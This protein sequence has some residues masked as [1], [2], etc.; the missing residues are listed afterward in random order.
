[1]AVAV[2]DST[3]VTILSDNPIP[4]IGDDNAIVDRTQQ[5]TSTFLFAQ[6]QS[7]QNDATCFRRIVVIVVVLP[8]RINV[9][10]RVMEK[11][12]AVGRWLSCWAALIV[13][14]SREAELNLLQLLQLP[15]Q[16]L[17]D[18]F[19]LPSPHIVL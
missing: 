9:L 17:D 1:M 4:R 2:A 11:R 10:F 15:R 13:T 14:L 19:S 6:A 8:V 12:P 5:G 3:S 7:P 16:S 18:A